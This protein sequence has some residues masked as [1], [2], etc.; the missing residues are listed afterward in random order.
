MEF[1]NG[2]KCLIAEGWVASHKVGRVARALKRAQKKSGSLIPSVLNEL[3]SRDT[4]PTYIATTEFTKGFQGIVNS[5]GIPRYKEINPAVFTMITFPFEFGIMFGDVGHGA[6]LFALA[7]SLLVYYKA[8]DKLQNEITDMILKGRYVLLFMSICSIYMGALYNEFFQVSMN[9]GSSWV[10][11]EDNVTWNKLP[12]SYVFGVDPIWKT[13]DNSLLYYNSLKMKMAIIIGIIQM[14]LG[15]FLKLLNAIH[16]GHYIDIFFEFIPQLAFLLSIFGYLC[17][18]IFLKW[19]IGN[20]ETPLLLNVL[21]NMVIPGSAKDTHFYDGQPTIEI[22]LVLVA[23]GSIPVML[24]PKPIIIACMHSSLKKKDIPEEEKET[25]DIGGY[26]YKDFKVSEIIV[27][28]VLETIEFCLGTV[29]HTASYLRL[30]A[31]SLAHSELSKVLWEMLFS[32]AVCIGPIAGV[33]YLSIAGAFVGFAAWMVLTL[34]ILIFMESLSA[35]LHSLR[36]HWLEFQ[37]KFYKGDGL[38]FKPLA[39]KNTPVS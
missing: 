30:W 24:V 3:D 39:F 26:A 27:H 19:T 17:F 13:T 16:F 8:I 22:V 6:I 32:P 2:R 37:S 5:Y 28:Q 14:S 23:L 9:F 4:P 21:I 33:P 29:S 18:L 34:F 12:T 7:I 20:D 31:L 38:K 15:L 36:L 25:K 1:D 10:Q 11:N 35:G